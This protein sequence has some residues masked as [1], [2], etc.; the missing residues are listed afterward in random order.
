[1]L[2]LETAKVLFPLLLKGRFRHLDLW[3]EFLNTQ[4]HAISRDTYMLLL[5]FSQAVNEDMSNFDENG[6]WP[7]LIDEFV[8]YAKP[9]IGQ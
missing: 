4:R 9:K 5:D 1:M 8:E 3:V 7:V 2:P 6:A